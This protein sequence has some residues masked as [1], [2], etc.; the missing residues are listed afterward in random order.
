MNIH[1]LRY[2]LSREQCVIALVLENV[3]WL[4]V[5]V[6]EELSA[7]DP[8]AVHVH[9]G[10]V[11]VAVL[12]GFDSQHLLSVLCIVTA[13]WL[14]LLEHKNLI[15]LQCHRYTQIHRRVGN[16]GQWLLCVGSVHPFVVR[17]LQPESG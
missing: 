13:L 12:P 11:S 7:P 8:Q 9:I 6:R 14:A 10:N 1:N 5:Q 4:A 17:V 15:S 3:Q 16:T 2:W